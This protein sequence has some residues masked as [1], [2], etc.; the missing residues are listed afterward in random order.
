MA[1]AKILVVEDDRDILDLIRLLLES[2]R[3]EVVSAEDGIVG[4]RQF[5]ACQ[6]DLVLLDIKLPGMS[7]TQLCKEIRSISEVP[8]IFMSSNRD[9]E[10]IIAGL[11]SGA[12]DYVTKPFDPTVLAARVKANLRRVLATKQAVM[13][14]GPFEVDLQGREVYRDG[15]AVPLFTKEKQLLFFLLEH[16]NQV[17]SSEQLYEQIWEA[18]LGAGDPTVKVHI[19][20][21]RK[22]LEDDAENQKFIRTVRGFGYKLHME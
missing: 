21:L 7:G 4:L 5:K 14:L 17:F 19:S 6:P 8:I 12:D 1:E 15:K 20:N 22:K 13:K 9:A 11:D 18:D 3:Y 10:D 16:P 2:R